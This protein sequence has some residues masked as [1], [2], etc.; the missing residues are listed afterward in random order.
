M[1]NG[2]Q[3]EICLGIL[4]N[5]NIR[6][7][8][9][10]RFKC[11]KLDFLSELIEKEVKVLSLNGIITTDGENCVFA[12][13]RSGGLT[14]LRFLE[15]PEE[16]TS[17]AGDKRSKEEYKNVLEAMIMKTMKQ[18]KKASISVLFKEV[19]KMIH[20]DV[21]EVELEERVKVLAKKKYLDMTTEDE[22]LIIKYN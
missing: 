3:V 21:T 1:L 6:S 7:Q 8:L 18:M 5:S 20:F 19:T 11:N 14:D 12:K 16:V 17:G 4:N 15:I 10:K 22:E 9:E 2:V 13:K